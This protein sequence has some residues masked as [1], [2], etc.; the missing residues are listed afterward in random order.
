MSR[1]QILTEIKKYFAI[2]ELV[3]N[4]VYNR[5]GES[6][7][8]LLP[9]F[10]LETL[11]AVRIDILQKPMICNQYSSSS[12]MYTQRGTRCNICQL[13]K[14][15]TKDGISYNSAHLKNI[16]G[17]FNVIGMTAEEARKKIDEKQDLLPY[18]IRLESGV[19]WLHI[20]GYDNDNGKKI[21]YFTE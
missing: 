15:A 13:T 11:L 12:S 3:C 5:F 14:D 8:F 1:T 9:S 19:S 16:A 18:P 4:H 17:D 10:W 7:W 20:D 6:A 2:K 21:T